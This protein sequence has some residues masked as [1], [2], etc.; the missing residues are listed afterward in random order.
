MANPKVVIVGGGFGGIKAA[1]ALKKA[2]VDLLIIDKTNHHLFQPLLYQI[3]TAALSASSIAT[4]IRE[5][6]RHQKNTSVIMADVI[7]IHKERKRVELLTR[8]MI[9]YD[10][11]VVATGASH[12]YFGHDEWEVLAPGLKTLVDAVKIR[13]HLLLSFE[14]AERCDNSLDAEKYLRFVVIGGGPTGVEMAGAI[15]EIAHTTLYSNFRK[16]KPSLCQIYLIEGLEYLLPSYPIKLCIQAQKDLEQLGVT[17]LTNT[18]VTNITP[19]G[20]YMGDEFIETPNVIWAAGN[21]AS[22]L[23]KTLGVPLDR[24]GR[25]LVEP[26]L[27]I[28]DNPNVF[29][30]GDAA[31]T[32]DPSFGI[33]PG[34]A[35]VAIQQGNYVAKIISK[36][37]PKEK[38]KPFK[39]F[40][41]GSM[42]TIGKGKAVATIGKLAFSGFFA[43][44]AWGLIHIAYLINFRNRIIV[45]TQWILWFFTGSRNV[46]IIN[47]SIEV[48]DE[49]EICNQSKK[50]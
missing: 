8:E 24:Q 32:L 37:I 50:T 44:L 40:D 30:I 19:E 17:V 20:V 36:Q 13:E 28:P 42:A 11:L 39:Y 31:A 1:R 3:A 10:Y 29:V 34:V 43:W 14:R 2:S 27:S 49:H 6:V 21:E 15:A 9:S 25:V 5:I 35:P 45:M 33:L 26:D 23:L 48:E 47:K 46:R 7:A 41:K 38:R 18:R 22:P 4:P 12:A 16:I